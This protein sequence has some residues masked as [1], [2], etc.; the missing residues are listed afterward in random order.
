MSPNL[1]IGLIVT[2][3]VLGLIAIGV[4]CTTQGML[5]DGVTLMMA[6]ACIMFPA[7]RVSLIKPE[8]FE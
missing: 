2:T 6:L 3:G 4:L 1:Q 7:W 5:F 8:L